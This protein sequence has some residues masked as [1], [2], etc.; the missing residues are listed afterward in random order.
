MVLT[1]VM[2][3]MNLTDMKEILYAFAVKFDK[4]SPEV[5]IKFVVCYSIIIIIAAI[6]NGTILYV[7][8]TKSSLRRPL[9]LVLSLLLWKSIFLLLTA[10][11]VTLLELCIEAV[12]K[13][14]YLVAI[15]NYLT[16]FYIWLSFYIVIHIGLNRVRAVRQ[17]SS[18]SNTKQSRYGLL[19]FII[20]TTISAL[21]PL[22]TIVIYHHFGKK[23]STLFSCTKVFIMT[24]VLL[25]SYGIIINA[26][27]KSYR[28]WKARSNSKRLL[29]QNKR[30]L[31]KVKHTVH[32][33]IGG[34]ALTLVPFICSS[35]VES[36]IYYKKDSAEDDN[37]FLPTFR[38]VGEM[39]LY[40]NIIF[41]PIIYFYTQ[42]DL[43]KEVGRLRFAKRFPLR[44][45]L[46][47]TSKTTCTDDR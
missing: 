9:K 26:V 12:S 35:A 47:K 1:S 18:I 32:L 23:A 28:G 10:M 27:K 17:K 41:N 44:F 5:R 31:K 40:L 2:G 8:V 25:V 43:M 42:T 15:Q 33:V 21:M 20:G 11:P 7:F 14:R 36:Y 34:Y 24:L 46:S 13:N 29:Q 45:K 39:V 16:M 38:A 37:S 6:L 19:F 4:F 22:T 30:M 3:A